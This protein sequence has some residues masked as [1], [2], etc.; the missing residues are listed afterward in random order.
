MPLDF[1][2]IKDLAQFPGDRAGVKPEPKA[3]KLH[4][5]GRSPASPVSASH[6]APCRMRQGYRVE[7]RVPPEPPVLVVQSGGDEFRRDVP[8]RSVK[9]VFVVGAECDGQPLPMAVK[10]FAGK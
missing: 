7:P 8:E 10:D 6:K 1:Q 2:R 3:R 5:D 4:G 9:T